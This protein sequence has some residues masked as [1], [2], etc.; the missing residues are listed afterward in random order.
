MPKTYAYVN[1]KEYGD[2]VPITRADW[3]EETQYA[4]IYR[5]NI[6]RNLS[7]WFKVND[8]Y[9]PVDRLLTE[10]TFLG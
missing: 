4:E 1:E 6:L 7:F 9:S 10:A 2:R 8:V 3:H 5:D